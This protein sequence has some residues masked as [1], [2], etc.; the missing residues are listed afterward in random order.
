MRVPNRCRLVIV[1]PG[2][3]TDCESMIIEALSGGDVASV[4]VTS[5]PVEDV[6]FQ[7]TC[8]TVVPAIQ[9]F[10][11]AVVIAGDTRVAGRCNADGVHL[12]LPGGDVGVPELR[13]A[14]AK[15]APD[16]IVGAG[17]LTTRHMALS[18]GEADPDY[19]FSANLMA[20]SNQRPTR[21]C[22]R[23]LSGGLK[24]L[25]CRE[26]AWAVRRLTVLLMLPP[27]GS[28]LLP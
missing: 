15:Y 13:E 23:W 8:A 19:V 7:A 11:A 26:S 6:T 22:W 21:N 18:L 16:K 27:P 25:R 2:T 14:I 5:P 17:S 1:M 20:I 9:R 4:I 24:W 3:L 28:I 10:G 12:D